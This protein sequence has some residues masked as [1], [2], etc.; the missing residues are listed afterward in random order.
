MS[1][2]VG[3]IPPPPGIMPNFINPP[4]L[5]HVVLIV[6][7]I[8]SFVS[9]V[10]VALR[11]YTTGFLLRSVGVDGCKYFGLSKN[12]YRANILDMVALAWV[13]SQPVCT[14]TYLNLCCF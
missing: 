11:F 9:L 2:I 8:L 3:A 10:F 1:S 7:V 5:Q 4:S 6:N 14:C 12:K 13:S